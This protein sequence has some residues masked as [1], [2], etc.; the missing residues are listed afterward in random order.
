MPLDAMAET[1]WEDADPKAFAAAWNAEVAAVPEFE[2]STL[3]VVAGLLLPIWKRLPN[4]STRVYRLQT[5]DGERIVGR[6]VSPAW[7]AATLGAEAPTLTAHAAWPMLEAGDVTLHL[8][9]GQTLARVRAMN[10]PR[11]ELTGFNDLAIERLKA[12]GLISEIVS[13][14]LRLFVPT[15][16]AGPDVLARL[17]ERYPLQRV[18]ERHAA[19][20][21]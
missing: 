21:A 16:A 13:W 18:A 20:A 15:G 12:I 14:K 10:V 9:E 1:Q 8:A 3:H 5:D 6:R 11:I 17:M 7:A 2:T 19:K 4:Q